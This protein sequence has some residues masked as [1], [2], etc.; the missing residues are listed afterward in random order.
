MNTTRNGQAPPPA[1][2]NRPPGNRPPNGSG[3]R[4]P[5][6]SGNHAGNR[7]HYGGNNFGRHPNYRPSY[8]QFYFGP[9]GFGYS[10]F[11]RGFGISVGL[12]IN[13]YYQYY[14][15]AQPYFVDTV[16][17]YFVDPYPQPYYTQYA[18]PADTIIDGAVL[19]EPTLSA[20]A[21]SLPT[22]NPVYLDGPSVIPAA[23]NASEFQAQ[24]EQAFR[25]QRYEDAA[26]SSNHALIEDPGNGLLHLFASQ[27]FF[28]LGDYRSS[29]AAL[30][31]G[32]SLLEREQWGF[33]VE[34]YKQF[35]RGKD[36]VTHMASLVE[37][38]RNDS[39]QPYAHFLR[40][41]HYLYLGYA[42]E[43]QAPL[44]KAVELEPRDRLAAE[45]LVTAGGQ[46]PE[47]ASTSRPDPDERMRVEKPQK[48]EAS[49]PLNPPIEGELNSPSKGEAEKLPDPEPEMPTD[50]DN[51]SSGKSGKT[52]VDDSP[53]Q[54]GK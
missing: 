27:V 13:R 49:N 37:F 14:D 12:P 25:E 21:P 29:A 40:G 24:A 11:G 45:L 39:S 20:P 7:H 47:S 2:G 38:I 54:A 44:L 36:Y 6:G 4:P 41:Y 8:N 43:A 22:E 15:V 18:L 9:G 33:V 50:P 35:Y 26:R 48:S 34:N 52:V 19:G 17:P 46:L 16:Q 30:Q 51:S 32:A 31:L 1:T 42:K 3:N 53:P 5:K 28:A 10:Y 23:G